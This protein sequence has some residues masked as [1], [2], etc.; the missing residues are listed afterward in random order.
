MR[1]L[2]FTLS[3]L[4]LSTAFA[5][6]RTQERKPLIG[7]IE[8]ENSC[9]QCHG[10]TGRGNGERAGSLKV[11]PPDLTQLSKR[12]DGRFPFITVYQVIDGSEHVG[13][14]SDGER[15]MPIWGDRY[16]AEGKKYG[17]DEYLYAR[18]LILELIDYLISI[19]VQ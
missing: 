9:A 10:S 14:H 5:D 11:P 15:E 17:M 3:I 19:Q 18:G 1:Y 7:G 2:I 16:R 12:N 4:L 6:D 8:F 13:M